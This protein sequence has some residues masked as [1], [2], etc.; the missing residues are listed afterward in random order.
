MTKATTE[1]RLREF[2]LALSGLIAVG[3]V[4][5]LLL[6]LHFEETLQWI[7]FVLCLL[8]LAMVVAVWRRPSRRSIRA[9][10]A[11]MAI[12]IAGSAWGAV[13]HLRGNLEFLLETKPTA[14]TAQTLWGMLHGG[15]PALASGML[16]VMAL[17][18]LA[19]TYRHPALIEETS[20]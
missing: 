10:W 19:A 15:S 7:P 5:E 11:V 14:S 4:A 1:A 6:L 2:L 20:P 8:A 13:L 18:G 16:V 12:V 3:S 17:A 9:L